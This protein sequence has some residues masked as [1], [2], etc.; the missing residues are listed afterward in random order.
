LENGMVKMERGDTEWLMSPT[1]LRQHAKMVAGYA[2][3]LAGVEHLAE[4]AIT[5]NRLESDVR[6][7]KRADA[8]DCSCSS[9]SAA[10]PTTFLT[11]RV[12]VAAK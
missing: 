6:R 12:L 10:P 1:E 4:V 5:V 7:L 2:N 8:A 9:H 3:E 11:R